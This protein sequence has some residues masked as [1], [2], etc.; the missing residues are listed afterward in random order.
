MDYTCTRDDV[1]CN[2]YTTRHRTTLYP[3]LIY[4]NQMNPFCACNASILNCQYPSRSFILLSISFQKLYPSANILL[5]ALSYCQY[6][7]RCMSITLISSTPLTSL[8]SVL[9]LVHTFFGFK[10]VKKC[11]QYVTGPTSIPTLRTTV[12]SNNVI[13]TDKSPDL[14][15]NFRISNS[16]YFQD[17]RIVMS[18]KQLQCSGI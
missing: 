14:D 2:C 10:T 12:L 7:F 5:E 15:I 11:K 8:Y 17:L 1:A 16:I 3:T 18:Y 13:Q 4:S 9:L 6:P